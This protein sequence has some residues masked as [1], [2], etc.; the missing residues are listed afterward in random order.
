M[1]SAATTRNNETNPFLF[2]I[3]AL[4]SFSC[5]SQ[6]TGPTAL[7]PIRK[8]K[9]WLSVLDTS[10]ISGTTTHTL[11]IRNTRVWIWCS[12]PLNHDTSDRI[13]NKGQQHIGSHQGH[14]DLIDRQKININSWW[15]KEKKQSILWFSRLVTETFS[16]EEIERLVPSHSSE[17]STPC[18]TASIEG[19]QCKLESVNRTNRCTFI[20]ITIIIIIIGWHGWLVRKALASH[21]G[22][23]GSIPGQGHMWV[24]LCVGSL[25]C[26]KGFPDH[27]V[28]LPREKSNTFDLGC[29]PW[30]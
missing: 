1:H 27:P 15:W 17:N 20:I 28:F 9:P 5:I 22:D 16:S 6:H 18:S 21:Q 12:Q 13:N 10:V 25:L 2:L 11:L 3:S 19:W 26:H 30:S 8:T 29:A 4:G 24:E 23:P 14:V 7:H